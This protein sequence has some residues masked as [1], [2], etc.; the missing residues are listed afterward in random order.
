MSD[1]ERLG[2][3]LGRRR[4]PRPGKR[5]ERLELLSVRWE[6][7]AG[8]RLAEHS[9]PSSLDRG[10]LTVSA[11]GTAWASEASAVAGSILKR[12]EAELGRG[13]VKRI[14]VRARTPEKEGGMTSAPREE[15]PGPPPEELG[16]IKDEKLREAV[17]R[18]LKASKSIEQNEHND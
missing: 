18:M 11:E 14:K 12:I 2:S 15:D 3:L 5:R 7:I 8:E 6:R 1:P 16:S 9:R 13:V 17:H 4:V 10:T